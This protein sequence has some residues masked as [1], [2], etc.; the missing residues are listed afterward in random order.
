MARKPRSSKRQ[1]A[2]HV[3][4]GS[5]RF[6][7]LKVRTPSAHGG[8]GWVR[9]LPD[10]R[11]FAY[12]AP[13]FLFPKGLPTSVDLRGGCPPVYDSGPA[14]QLHCQRH[15]RRDPVR[16]DQ[17]GREEPSRRRGCSSTTTSA[18]SKGPSQTTRARRYATGSS[19]S[20]PSARHLKRRDWP[21]D[22]ARFATKPPPKAYKDAKQDLVVAYAR[23]P[24]DLGQMQG[25]PSRRLSVRVR[26]QRL[27]KLRKRDGRPDRHR[28]DAGFRRRN[29]SGGHAVVAVG[30]DDTQRAFV[31]RNSWGPGWGLKGYFWIPYEYL[32]SPHLASDFWTVR[33]VSG[34]ARI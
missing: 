10:A 1:K 27:S 25:M 19:L 20:P 22:I 7:K 31:V 33:S 5:D 13:L 11:D 18:S 28:P 15:R 4:N 2:T 16:P 29:C 14:R 9:D 34:I 30:Y 8:Y 26:L 12:S 6:A 23:V 24:Q 17:A 32:V 21:Y 3:A